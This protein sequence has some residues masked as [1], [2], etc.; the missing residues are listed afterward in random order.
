MRQT[1]FWIAIANGGWNRRHVLRT[2]ARS[3][4]IPA[5]FLV[6]IVA[7]NLSL[8]QSNT[9]AD[10]PAPADLNRVR[11]GQPAPAFELQDANGQM[12]TLASFQG[13]P[14]VLVFYR[15]SW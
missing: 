13:R 1:P 11:P 3:L 7:G 12:Q 6:G 15:G 8:A 10:A 9:D 4:V 5:A 14:V 2:F